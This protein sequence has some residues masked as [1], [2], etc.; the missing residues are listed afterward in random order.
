MKQKSHS[1]LAWWVSG[2]LNGL[3]RIYCWRIYA[4][5]NI[6]LAI[7]FYVASDIPL[8]ALPNTVAAAMFALFIALERRFA[9]NRS[10]TR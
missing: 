9:N 2:T 3:V 4:V 1:Q 8:S 6:A 7:A 5:L 10:Q